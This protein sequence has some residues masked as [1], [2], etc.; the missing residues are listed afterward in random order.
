MGTIKARLTEMKSTIV[1]REEEAASLRDSLRQKEVAMRRVREEAAASA[2]D[3]V[4][5]AKAEGEETAQRHLGFID[6]LLGDKKRLAAR[7]EE[8]VAALQGERFESTERLRKLR[9]SGDLQGKRLKAECAAGE[10]ARLATAL[11]RK[12][13]SVRSAVMRSLEPDIQRLMDKH[14][15]DI[16]LLK[17]AYA[18]QLHEAETR[19]AASK[20]GELLQL[21]GGVDAAVQGALREE[22]HA[23]RQR[24]LEA[25]AQYDAEVARIRKASGEELAAEQRRGLEA[26]RREAASAQGDLQRQRQQYEASLASAAAAHAAAREQFESSGDQSLRRAR[27]QLD[28]ERASLRR[29]LQG[30]LQGELLQRAEVQRVQLQKEADEALRAAIQRLDAQMQAQ[31]KSVREGAEARANARVAEVRGELAR[32]HANV[33]SLREKLRT[34]ESSAGSAQAD[35]SRQVTRVEED[36]SRVSAEKGRLGAQVASLQSALE[37]AT[38]QGA[39]SSAKWEAQKAAMEAALRAATHAAEDKE[40]RLEQKLGDAQRDAS[41]AAAALRSKHAQAAAQVQAR[42]SAALAEKEAALSDLTRA[43][44]SERQLR[45]SAQAQLQ[46]ER[47]ELMDAMQG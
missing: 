17:D 34:A 23:M 42:V 9:E 19:I 14:K 10:K 28:A 33:D 26:L 16:G 18:K 13:A 35:V 4:Q 12:E 6:K 1:K 45:Q 41:A 5:A 15:S 40:R 21:K 29:D 32:A 47:R 36:L 30:E 24:E 37:E 7:C 25:A 46:A 3:A 2:A 43:L 20:Q 38:S 27:R 22:R 44:H 11:E 8:L 39:S 31:V